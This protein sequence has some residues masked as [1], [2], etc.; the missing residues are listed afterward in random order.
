MGTYL[1]KHP[2]WD[3]PV[4]WRN[5]SSPALFKPIVEIGRSLTVVAWITGSIFGI[6]SKTIGHV[7]ESMAPPELPAHRVLKQL[8]G[9]TYLPSNL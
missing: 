1:L 3:T 6:G 8:I 5:D 7:V 9:F 2:L 4:V